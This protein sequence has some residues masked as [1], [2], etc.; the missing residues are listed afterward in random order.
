MPGEL[1]R[2]ACARCGAVYA[3][4]R[5]A[6]ACP[7]CGL[8]AATARPARAAALWADADAF[9]VLV[10]LGFTVAN[11]L[12]LALVAVAINQVGR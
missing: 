6:G 11:L 9:L 3:P 5:T 2:D 7:L 4:S 10:V 1:S 8:A 12:L